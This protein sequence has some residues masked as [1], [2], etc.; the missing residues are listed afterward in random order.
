MQPAS[1][2]VERRLRVSRASSSSSSSKTRCARREDAR[3]QRCRRSK[4]P[5]AAGCRCRCA[6][7]RSR[8]SSATATSRSASPSTSASGAATRA[9]PTSRAPRSSRRCARPTT[10]R[11][12]PPRT[13]PPACPT[14][15]TSRSA[16]PPRATS[17]CSTRGP[18]DAAAAAELARAARRRRSTTDRAH[19]QLRRRRRVGAA[20]ALLCRQHARLSRR[21]CQLAPLAL[22]GADRRRRRGDMQRDAWYSSMR[23]PASWRRPR[24]SAAMPPSARCRAWRRA[25]SPTCEVPVLFESTLAA[26]LLGAYVQATSGGALY[27]KASFLHR[28]P[29]HSRCWPTHVDIA[30]GPAPCRRARA[31]RR[32]TTKA[33]A[34]ARAA[35][36][37]DG[38]V[39]GYFLSSYSARKLGLR[40]TGHAGGSQNLVLT[41]RLTAA[42]RRPRRDAAQA[43]PRPVR[44]R[45]DGAG[46]QLRDR[47]LFARRGRLLG[48]ER[49][50]RATRCTRSPSPATCARCSR[51]SSRSVPTPTRSARKTI[52]SV[53]IERMKVAGA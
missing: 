1:P 22:G 34:R 10:S 44:H 11:A 32:S 14:T 26:G 27:R 37:T 38:V 20:V 3:R 4:S 23:D 45:A 52:G 2:V 16:T 53:L 29:G 8:T 40:T 30:R 28:Q 9:R 43:R 35:S 49:A 18:I 7:A 19:H 50:H 24:R 41:S 25:R 12:S 13:R 51:T 47:R 15:A 31:A 6:R 48:R 42:R 5:K 46:R 17:T 36:S 33:C 21:L 39:Q